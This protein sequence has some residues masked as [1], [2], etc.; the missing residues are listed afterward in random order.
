M[1]KIVH[2]FK[3]IS[4]ALLL[5][6]VVGLWSFVFYKEPARVLVFSKTMVFRHTS[7]DTGK[8]A[9]LKMGQEH[10]FVVDTTQD[11]T[12][13]N[14]DNLK[15]YQA[16][17]FLSTTGD[18]LNGEQ[19]NSFERYI[20]AGGGYLGIHAA[21][22]TEYGWPWYGQLAGAW[23]DNHPM[24]D[25]VQKGTFVITNKTNP[26]TSFL[27][28]RWEREDEF[29]AF[30]NISPK[31]KVLLKIDEKTYSGGTN[32]D[33]HPDG[34]VPGIRRRACFLYGGRSH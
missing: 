16:V 4:I 18:V 7:I 1:K 34:L 8:R 15:R 12:K 27:P 21:A 10:G 2:R 19:Q 22:D 32:G 9:L 29:Y 28:E 33:N 31:I 13:F 6:A 5:L 26:A 25:N 17:I 11:A 24:P 14:E 20:Q 30:K 3:L 23:F